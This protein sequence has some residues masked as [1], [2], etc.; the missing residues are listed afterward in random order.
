MLEMGVIEESHSA[1][2]SPILLTPK[3]D[4][5]DR[6]CNDF[7][8]LNEISELDAY[9]FPRVDEL[10]E[11]LGPS[12]FVSTLDITNGYWVLPFGVHGVPATFQRMMDQ[13]LQPHY[14]YAAAY[15]DD[16]I[17]SPEWTSHRGHL[18]AVLEALQ[19]KYRRLEGEE[20]GKLAVLLQ[21]GPGEGGEQ[22]P[23]LWKQGKRLETPQRDRS[24]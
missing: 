14:E 13:I 7:R 21:A 15:L 19:V 22:T 9:S 8:K 16:I 23:A 11:R 4:G 24:D 2:S 10:I 20:E 1:W 12:H 3:L 5:T 18:R 6:F 17:H